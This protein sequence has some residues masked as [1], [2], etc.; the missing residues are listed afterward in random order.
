MIK[1]LKIR[2]KFLIMALLGAT[3]I[4]LMSLLAQNILEDGLARVKDV[5]KDSK[6]VQN[7]QHNF[8]IPLFKLREATLSLVVAPN[9]EYKRDIAISLT[10]MVEALD[11]SFSTLD[12]NLKDI[13]ENYKKLIFVRNGYKNYKRFVYVTDGYIK[14]DYKTGAFMHT[15]SVERKQFYILISK[16]KKLQDSQL[17][18]S[19][20]TFQKAKVSFS[21]KQTII[22]ASAI[23]VII[24]TL[25]FGFL[26]AR[27]I[28]FSMESVQLGLGK[29]FDLLGR[30]IDKDEKI[31][32]ELKSTD[33]FGEMAKSINTNVEILRE[34]LKKDIRLIEDATSVVSDL[35]KG[36]LDRRLVENASSSELN[37]LKEV[38]NQML[39]NLEDRIVLEINNRTKQEQLLIQQSKLASMG[40]MIGN[41]AHQWRQPL[42]E[43]NAVLMNMQVKKEHNDLSDVAFEQSIQECDIILAHMS[44]TINDF[45]NFFKPSKEKSRFSLQ[46]EC[47]NASYII[48]ASLKYNSISFEIDIEQDCQIFGY[49]REFSQAILNILSNAKDVLVERKIKKPYIKLILKKGKKY[50]LVKIED[51]AGGIKENILERIFEPYFTTKHATQGTGIGLYM[52]KIIIEDNMHGYIDMQ[53]G[54]N[55]AIFTIKLMQEVL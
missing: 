33:E 34:K 51:N 53:N 24:L 44:N 8:I 12:C 39:G 31:K 50:A 32:I 46:A 45:Q 26:I 41:I 54:K 28:V 3:A 2:Y 21:K 23:I 22:T 18:N 9:G 17:E 6:K 35:K 7:I 30:K 37:R 13:W 36:N 27:S 1:Y 5:F 25:L 48:E 19:Y 52:S 29:F 15:K 4:V 38:M 55:G 49:P 16:L 14:Q 47:K 42:S 40:N 10:P 20:N 43:I 11:Y